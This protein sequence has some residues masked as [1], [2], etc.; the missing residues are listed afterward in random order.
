MSK[1]TEY[2]LHA[3]FEVGYDDTPTIWAYQ[4]FR[5]RSGDLAT[6]TQNTFDSHR[7]SQEETDY[8]LEKFRQSNS[9]IDALDDLYWDEWFSNSDKHPRDLLPPTILKW[10]D[11]LP[12]YEL[13]EL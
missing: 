13:E 8:V 9:G 4:L 1:T 6:D 11:N 2:D 10:I 7:F 12:E 5:E 3:Q